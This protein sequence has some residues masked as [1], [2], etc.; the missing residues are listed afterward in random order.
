MR[1]SRII[2]IALILII[3]AIAIAALISLARTVFFSG[4]ASQ[5]VSQV[6]VSTD[7]LLN[8]AINHSVTLTVR[9]TIVADEDFR[10]YQIVVTPTSRTLTTY[11]G[12]LDAPISQIAVSN[13]TPAYE[14]FVYALDRANLV[15]GT[16]LTGTDNDTRGVC[17]DGKLYEFGVL[18]DGK[19]VKTLWTSS[20]SESKGSLNANVGNL[21]D[22]FINQIP[23]GVELI[24]AIVL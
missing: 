4:S 1:N 6:D 11:S 7:A 10:S 8:T 20:C 5:T 24:N 3:I 17:A 2:P 9:G 18:K 13:N 15:K 19:S 23:K 14:Q 16:E 22:M 21:T 12:Y